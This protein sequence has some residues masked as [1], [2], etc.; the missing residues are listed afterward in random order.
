MATA[1]KSEKHEYKKQQ[2]D[3]GNSSGIAKSM[4]EK[5]KA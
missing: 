4:N 2:H 3:D 1:M 5:R